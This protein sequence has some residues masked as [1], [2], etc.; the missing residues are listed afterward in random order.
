M[1]LAFDET[2][3]A[4]YMW[5]TGKI[6][7]KFADAAQGPGGEGIA[8]LLGRAFEGVTTALSKLLRSKVAIEI[9]DGKPGC[10][11][12]RNGRADGMQ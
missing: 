1:A 5:I 9:P 12:C 3:Y 2:G 6:A 8:G 10:P 7:A 4:S 11:R